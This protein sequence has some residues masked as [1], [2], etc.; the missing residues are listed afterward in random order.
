MDA[1]EWGGI[2]ADL[3]AGAIVGACAIVLALPPTVV[4]LVIGIARILGVA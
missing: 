2:E 3:T 4:A 1:R